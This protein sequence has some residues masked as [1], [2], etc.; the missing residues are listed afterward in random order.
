MKFTTYLATLLLI[1]N[2]ACSTI[3]FHN[4]GSNREFT[5]HSEWHHDWLYGLIEG[6]AAVDMNERCHD[7]EWETIETKE[8]FV[9]GLIAGLTYSI[10]TPQN[11]AYACFKPKK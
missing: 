7:H 11:M 6:S 3:Y 4:D 9:Q 2:T 5:S 8:S 1:L 10:Y